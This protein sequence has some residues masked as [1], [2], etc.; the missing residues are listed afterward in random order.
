MSKPIHQEVV[1]KASAKRIYEALTDSKKFSE[2]TGGAPADIS[3]EA[4]GAFSV[5]GGMIS[6]RNIEALADQRLVQAWRAGNWS[7]GIYSVARFE[8]KAQGADTLLVF[9]Q[10]GFPPEYRDDLEKGWSKMYW[11]PIKKYLG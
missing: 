5:F 3:K 6:G 1:I 4:G 10:A 9:D 8:L 7:D 2:L 11:D